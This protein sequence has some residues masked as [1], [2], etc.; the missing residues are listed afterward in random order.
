MPDVLV[1]CETVLQAEPDEGHLAAREESF[2]AGQFARR[3]ADTTLQARLQR[4][5]VRTVGLEERAVGA[6][7]KIERLVL[8]QV[9]GPASKEP[10]EVT[11]SFLRE[12]CTS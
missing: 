11:R 6:V 8:Q 5:H 10:T 7:G 4:R 2:F 1:G 9:D 12:R 3:R